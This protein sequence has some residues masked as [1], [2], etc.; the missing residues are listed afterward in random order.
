MSRL[1]SINNLSKKSDNCVMSRAIVKNL[2]LCKTKNKTSRDVKTK[3]YKDEHVKTLKSLENVYQKVKFSETVSGRC[4]MQCFLWGASKKLID[5]KDFLSDSQEN[6]TLIGIILLVLYGS[7]VTFKAK[8]TSTVRIA[9][10]VCPDGFTERAEIT[11]GR[12]AMIGV[13]V[14]SL[15]NKN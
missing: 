7:I 15:L 10:G 12:F 11:N 4:A 5:N 2:Y 1:K 8:D 6:I 9:M 14:L 3:A 13:L